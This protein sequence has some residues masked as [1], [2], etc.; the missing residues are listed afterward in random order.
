MAPKVKIT[1][2]D[3]LDA[4]LALVRKAG[5]GA[6]NARDL[7]AALDCSTQPIFTHFASMD[8]LRLA[9]VT[10]AERLCHSYVEQEIAAEKYPPYKASG[11]AYIRFARQERNLFQ[12]LYM[13]DRTGE[14]ESPGQ[15]L[16]GV[17][18]DLAGQVMDREPAQLARFHMEMWAVVHGFATMAATGFLALEEDAVSTMITDVFQ[19]LKKQHTEE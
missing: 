3:V 13:R 14:Q 11:M 12:L 9:L 18:V 10:E 6:L 2:Q 8:Q 5:E 16:W 17:G 7:A 4:G 19:G 1:R 15:F